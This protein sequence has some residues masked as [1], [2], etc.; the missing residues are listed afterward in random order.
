MRRLRLAACC[1]VLVLSGCTSQAPKTTGGLGNLPLEPSQ[2]PGTLVYRAP[3]IPSGK[4]KSI[5]V[6]AA[7]IYRAA[8]ADFGGA[9]EE[10][11]ARLAEKLTT[12]FKSALAKHHYTLVSQSGQG[13]VRLHLILAGIKESKPVAATALRLTPLGLGMSAAKSATGHDNSALVGSV[14]VSGELLDTESGEALAGFVATESPIALDI[15]SGFGKLRAAELG[16]ERGSEEFAVALDRYL[17]RT[18]G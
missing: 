5:F 8:D 18:P 1:G 6:D 14:T 16:I 3:D 2:Y 11:K 10:D 4:Y 7:D 13:V 9:S 12:E 17:H 15:S